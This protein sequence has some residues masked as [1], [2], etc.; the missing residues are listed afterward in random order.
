MLLKRWYFVG[1]R[2]VDKRFVNSLLSSYMGNFKVPGSS[3]LRLLKVLII[4]SK[5]L[6]HSFFVNSQFFSVAGHC[7]L[8]SSSNVML[9]DKILKWTSVG[10]PRDESDEVFFMEWNRCPLAAKVTSKV[11][12]V[13][14][15]FFSWVR[16]SC[17]WATSRSNGL[18]QAYNFGWRRFR[19]ETFDQCKV[20]WLC[21]TR[22]GNFS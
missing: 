14:L 11:R 12:L 4:G 16:S 2:R 13:S 3:C 9:I 7:H 1:S 18:V 21:R 17:N 6:L 10:K 19:E 20:C 22:E 5:F 15:D 8:I